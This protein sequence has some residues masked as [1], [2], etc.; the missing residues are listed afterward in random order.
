M[1]ADISTNIS[2]LAFRKGG[3]IA[4]TAS[5]E[6]ICIRCGLPALELGAARMLAGS[7]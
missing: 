4:R 6:R 1:T 7:S 5:S 2:T 3:A